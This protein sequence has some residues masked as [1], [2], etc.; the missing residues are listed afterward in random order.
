MSYHSHILNSSNHSHIIGRT[1]PI[2][3][4]SVKEN[5][6]VVFCTVCKSCFLEDSWVY[7]NERHCEQYQTLDSIPTLPSKLVAKKRVEQLLSELRDSSSSGIINLLSFIFTFFACGLTLHKLMFFQLDIAMLFG[8][9]VGIIIVSIT[10]LFTSSRK[11]KRITRQDKNDVRL[12]YTH[13]EVGKDSFSWNDIEQIKYQRVI[14]GVTNAE[15]SS[16]LIYLKS[17]QFFKTDLPINNTLEVRKFLIG[18]G[19]IPR[20]VEVFFYSDDRYEHRLLLEI[21]EKS[22][23]K[24]QV[25]EPNQ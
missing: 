4:D 19:Q 22:D 11:F 20:F 13:I 5:D 3:G 1:D 23:G 12:F 24:I 17:D 18:F 10:S 16:L 8:G 6:R 21:Q 15:F 2:T 9:I 25:G 7:M 14:S